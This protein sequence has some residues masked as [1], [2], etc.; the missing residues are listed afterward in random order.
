MN[1]ERKFKEK[2]E[3]H[4]EK[5]VVRNVIKRGE[6]EVIVKIKELN[7]T[8][9]QGF[10]KNQ[11]VRAD[12]EQSRVKIHESDVNKLERIEAELIRRVQMTK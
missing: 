2:I 4:Q 6:D 12:T 7:E 8:K 3:W 11:G 9:L 10:K 1:E 5:K